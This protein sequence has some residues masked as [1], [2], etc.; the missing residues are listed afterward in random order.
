MNFT[1]NIPYCNRMSETA[2]RDDD[3]SESLIDN[4]QNFEDTTDKDSREKRKQVM[5]KVYGEG[6]GHRSSENTLKCINVV[7]RNTILP[8]LKF[9]SSG[10]RLGSF[11]KPDFS[12]EKSWVNILFVK[13][14]V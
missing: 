10:T 8:K 13:F 6:I 3:N 11:E 2:Q 4:T 5:L 7:V 9:V 12:D 1:D 14:L